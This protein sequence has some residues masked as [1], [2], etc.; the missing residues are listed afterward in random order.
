MQFF[1]DDRLHAFPFAVGFRYV[2][3]FYHLRPWFALFD[4]WS[5]NLQMKTLLPLSFLIFPSFIMISF[6]L[7]RLAVSHTIIEI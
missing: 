6:F 2:S 1:Y 3:S 4:L 5:L 7:D